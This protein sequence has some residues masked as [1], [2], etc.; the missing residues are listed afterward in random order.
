MT[1]FN[2]QAKFN[3]SIYETLECA[4]DNESQEC[5]TDEIIRNINFFDMVK[6][7][8]ILASQKLYDEKVKKHLKHFKDTSTGLWCTDRP[9]KVS[10]PEKMLFELK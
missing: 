5:I 8:E 10:D 2:R 7:L 6:V 9:E 1:Y 4:F 3:E